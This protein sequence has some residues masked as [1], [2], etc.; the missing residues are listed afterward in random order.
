MKYEQSEAINRFIL[1]TKEEKKELR[2]W[3]WS[4][5]A[6]LLVSMFGNLVAIT[7]LVEAL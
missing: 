1:Q 4:V 5:T 3:V 6:L 2:M 7:K